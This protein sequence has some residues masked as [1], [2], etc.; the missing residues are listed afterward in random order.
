MRAD[1]PSLL[2]GILTVV[3][4]GFVLAGGLVLWALGTVLSHLF[5]FSSPV[6][7]GGVVVGLVAIGVGALMGVIGRGRRVL[8]AIALGCAVASLPLAFGGFVVGFLLTAIG[9]AIALARPRRPTV[10]VTTASAPGPSP[11][12]T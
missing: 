3:G 4:G 7:L 11:P 2:A 5:G 12:F 1:R 10:V 8:G 6:F 9:G